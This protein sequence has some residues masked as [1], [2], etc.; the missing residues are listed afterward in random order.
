TAAATRARCSAS[1]AR[2]L[3]VS[4]AWRCSVTACS[5]RDSSTRW[6]RRSAAIRRPRVIANSNAPTT[7]TATTTI[8]TI[9]TVDILYLLGYF[10]EASQYPAGETVRRRTGGDLPRDEALA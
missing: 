7:I 2:P 3:R 1:S 10:E 9:T 5:R 4:A 6:R 8:T